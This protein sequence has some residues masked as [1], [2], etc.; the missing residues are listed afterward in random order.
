MLLLDHP[1]RGLDPGARD[2]LF[3]AIRAEVAKGLAV[4]FVGDTIA[5]I[6]ELSNRVLVMR[7]GAV[8]ARFDLDAGQH[9]HEEEIV[10]A[11]V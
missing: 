11:M 1:S 2:D 10:A 7:D 5:E 9:P 3:D 6:L 8:T 4:I